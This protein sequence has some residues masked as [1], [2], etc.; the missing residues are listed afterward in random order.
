MVWWIQDIENTNL[1]YS[2][3]LEPALLPNTVMFYCDMM[4]S[5]SLRTCPEE[6]A[7]AQVSYV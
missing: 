7:G 1:S 6:D 4:V 5:L 2:R 3:N